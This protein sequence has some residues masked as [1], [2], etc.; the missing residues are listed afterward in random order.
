MQSQ[1]GNPAASGQAGRRVGLTNVNNFNP[2]I[3]FENLL[4][5]KHVINL[6]NLVEDVLPFA[7]IISQGLGLEPPKKVILHTSKPKDWL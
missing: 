7:K 6:I 5:A 2:T 3:T 4:C 1:P